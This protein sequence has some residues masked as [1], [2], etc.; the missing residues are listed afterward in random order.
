MRKLTIVLLIFLFIAIFCYGCFYLLHYICNNNE[1]NPPLKIKVESIYIYKGRQ[2]AVDE[3]DG[4][5]YKTRSEVVVGK[6]Y[7]IYAQR[8]GYYIL[9]EVEKNGQWEN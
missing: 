9:V 4:Y 8:D 7:F 6:T 2:Y 3:K 1:Y 5:A